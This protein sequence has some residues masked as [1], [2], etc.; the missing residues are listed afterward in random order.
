MNRQMTR[1]LLGT[2]TALLFLIPLGA[3]AQ[4]APGPLSEAWIVTPNKGQSGEFVASLKEHIALR[5]EHGDARAWE[6]YTP[7]LGDELSRFVIR[8]CCF[9]WADLDAYTSWD[10]SKT[11]VADHFN[12]K[13]AP[14]VDKAE[15]YFEEIDWANSHWNDGSY[16]YF[17]VTE[18]MPR[19]GHINEFK[20][21]RV[22][23]SQI[24]IEQGWANDARSWLWMSRIGGK[25]SVSM[26][27]PHENYASM[28]GDGES[29]FE[30]LATKL[31]S[32]E[33]AME[34][35]QEFSSSAWSSEY[36]VWE[37]H[38]DLSTQAAD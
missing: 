21:A 37:H 8:S 1:R 4:E 38:P 15:H 31:G 2:I 18:F 16:R 3:P 32:S 26:V 6:V 22:K 12:E 33:A 28:G 14:L 35:M 25:P 9:N 23:L 10:E 30:F 24:A 11:E 7:L 29:F 13:V 17:A 34:L 36:E 19:A 27:V 5:S 20:S